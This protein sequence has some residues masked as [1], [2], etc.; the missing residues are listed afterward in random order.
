MRRLWVTARAPAFFVAQGF[1]RV[2]P[3]SESDALLGGCLECDQY[4]HGCDAEAL[5]KRLDGSRVLRRSVTAE[6]ATWRD[7]GSST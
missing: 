6:G 5:T 4:G 2:P 3:G 1:E 7:R